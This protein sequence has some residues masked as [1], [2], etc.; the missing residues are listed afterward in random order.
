MNTNDDKVNPAEN[1]EKEEVLQAILHNQ[2]KL[3]DAQQN[4]NTILKWVAFFVLILGVCLCVL[5]PL[6][7]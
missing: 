4:T 2:K 3:L 1:L 7:A 6:T 5:Q